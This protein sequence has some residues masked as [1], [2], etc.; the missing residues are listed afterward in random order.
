MGKTFRP[1]GC[2]RARHPAISDHS[3]P[4]SGQDPLGKPEDLGTGVENQAAL[5]R[6]AVFLPKGHDAARAA[7]GHAVA[8]ASL[9]PYDVQRFAHELWDYAE[10]TATPTLDVK[11][12]AGVTT[13]QV[14]IKHHR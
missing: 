12:V 3:P 13:H 11:E 1:V 4:G 10:L 6:L 8:G 2:S 7:T 5:D 9:I 14:W